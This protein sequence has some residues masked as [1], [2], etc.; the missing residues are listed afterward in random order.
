M[1]RRS[2]KGQAT[3][4]FALM[5]PVIFALLFAIVEYAYYLGAVHYVNY[6]T[7]AAARAL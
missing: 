6:A 7:F 3:T 1:L 4:E 2:R 5:I